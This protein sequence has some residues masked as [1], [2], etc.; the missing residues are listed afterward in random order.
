MT[1]RLSLSTIKEAYANFVVRFQNASEKYVLTPII[2]S[3]FCASV[4]L[5]GFYLE[6]IFRILKA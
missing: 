5:G 2:T 3:L 6:Q 4:K 1:T